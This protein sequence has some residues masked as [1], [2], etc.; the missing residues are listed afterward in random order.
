MEEG[1]YEHTAVGLDFDSICE[2]TST[3]HPPPSPTTPTPEPHGVILVGGYGSEG[4]TLGS[5]ENYPSSNLCNIPDLPGSGRGKHTLSIWEP[6]GNPHKNLVVCGGVDA[7]GSNTDTCVRWWSGLTSWQ[8]FTSLRFSRV[9]HS[10]VSFGRT[11]L[12]LGGEASP[13]TG[14]EFGIDTHG[15]KFEL[16]RPVLGAC[17]ISQTDT[18]IVTGG[19]TGGWNFVE[20]YSSD[21]EF[22][23]SLPSFEHGRRDHACGSFEDEDGRTV[24]LVTGGYG[25]KEKDSIRSTELLW[26]DT[27][28]WVTGNQR[29]SDCTLIASYSL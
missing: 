26:P 24:L 14:V 8:S 10:A 3:T 28:D 13:R 29:T 11:F 27:N 17:V 22:L 4:E 18:F 12:L 7:S 19:E 5:V 23:E 21:G 15:R 20:K 2:E 9:R 16:N 6:K 25:V 1:R